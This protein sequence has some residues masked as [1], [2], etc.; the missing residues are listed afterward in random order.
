MNLPSTLALAALLSACDHAAPAPRY[1]NQNGGSP[2]V[3][4][5]GQDPACAATCATAPGPILPYG[6]GSAGDAELWAG[7][8]GV[9]QI[10]DGGGAAF[11]GP[12]AD[13]PADT[14]G[15]EFAPPVTSDSDPAGVTKGNLF[16]LTRGP[17]GPV[18]GAGFEYQQVYTI[19]GGVLKCFAT[20]SATYDFGI[21]YSPCPREWELAPWSDSHRRATLV[22]F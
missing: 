17:S 20:S 9:W 11:Q 21:K 7:L 12:P 10:C 1:P 14:I 6:H 5:T 18:R 8:V 15:V 19:Y 4:D 22:P 13:A 2:G 16:F 3:Y